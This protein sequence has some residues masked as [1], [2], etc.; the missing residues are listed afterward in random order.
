[1]GDEEISV[2]ELQRL[3]EAV[4]SAAPDA[5]EQGAPDRKTAKLGRDKGE[6]G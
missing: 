2:D 6:L 5:R 4:R 1:M 3:K